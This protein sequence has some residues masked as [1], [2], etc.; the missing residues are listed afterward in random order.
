MASL[1]PSHVTPLAIL[2]EMFGVWNM[3]IQFSTSLHEV[4]RQDVPWSLFWA[5][6]Q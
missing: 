6:P 1:L 2:E 5:M 4:P 3:V